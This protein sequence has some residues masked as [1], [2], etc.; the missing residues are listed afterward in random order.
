VL[1][2]AVLAPDGSACVRKQASDTRDNAEALGRA[3]ADK[4]LE[5]GAGRL[6]QLAGRELGNPS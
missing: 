4:L 3:L 2:A 6:L 5:A 1:D